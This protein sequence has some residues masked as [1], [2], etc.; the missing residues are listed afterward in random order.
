MGQEMAAKT[1]GSR[2]HRAWQLTMGGDRCYR[3]GRV[4]HDSTVFSMGKG[5]FREY[6]LGRLR[7][8]DLKSDCIL[9]LPP[10]FFTLN[11]LF[12]LSEPQSVKWKY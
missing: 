9:A 2:T 12:N 5:L 11:K 1:L 3:E 8:Q 6:M 4:K 10:T 7:A